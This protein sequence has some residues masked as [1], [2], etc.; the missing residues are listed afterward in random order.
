MGI[1]YH[2]AAAVPILIYTALENAAY[3]QILGKLSRAGPVFKDHTIKVLLCGVDKP[4]ML[5][6]FHV[7][8]I[9]MSP[10]ANSSIKWTI[11]QT[12]R[13]WFDDVGSGM[14]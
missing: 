8:F 4:I 12:L 1:I 10:S 14:D 7:R 5:C 11:S 6:V 3:W 2:S 9:L 13:I